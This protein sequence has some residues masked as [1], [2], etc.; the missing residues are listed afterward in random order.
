[1]LTREKFDLIREKYGWS[2]SWAIWSEVGETQ[3]SNVGDL[4]VLDP[5]IN[6][7]LLSQL[8][9]GIVLI[10][11]NISRGVIKEPFANF[12]DKRSQATDY[13]N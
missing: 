3:K 11:L 1:M 9:T 2:S 7:G 13:K 6:T 4:S 8:N 5:D 10:G 12:H